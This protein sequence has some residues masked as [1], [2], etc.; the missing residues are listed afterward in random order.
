MKLLKIFLTMEKEIRI[1]K[2]VGLQRTKKDMGFPVFA[3]P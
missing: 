1:R 2:A 3:F